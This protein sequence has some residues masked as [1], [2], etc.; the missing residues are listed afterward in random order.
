MEASIQSG[1]SKHI[2]QA[3]IVLHCCYTTQL[4][5]E[6]QSV[7]FEIEEAISRPDPE[8][9]LTEMIHQVRLSSLSTVVSTLGSM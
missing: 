2:L 4:N 5:M 6:L 1:T 9:I 7:L 3:Y 8:P